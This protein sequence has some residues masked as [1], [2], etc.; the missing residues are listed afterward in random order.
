M[1][2]HFLKIFVDWS[3]P[4]LRLFKSR[5]L[6]TEKG[7]VKGSRQLLGR[8]VPFIAHW[9]IGIIAKLPQ[10]AYLDMYWAKIAGCARFLCLF[11]KKRSVLSVGLLM[12][13][14]FYPWNIRRSN[15]IVTSG[16]EKI[17]PFVGKWDTSVPNT[18]V[19]CRSGTRKYYFRPLYVS[20]LKFHYL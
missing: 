19:F 9:L 17:F 16:N 8:S 14:P 12:R 10:T 18:Y 15:S 5:F 3:S 13:S 2:R 1:D 4:L 20:I 11:T 6:S 7:P